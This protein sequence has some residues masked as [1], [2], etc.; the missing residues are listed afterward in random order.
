MTLEHLQEL[1]GLQEFHH[2]TYREKALYCYQN[3]DTT[4]S[5]FS[6]AGCF[7][8]HDEDFPEACML[9][10]LAKVPPKFE[11]DRLFVDAG[12]VDVDEDF[13]P[14]VEDDKDSVE[15]IRPPSKDIGDIEDFEF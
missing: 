15:V 4:R 5:G 6:L 13:F 7:Y 11:E 10:R 3:D 8:L 14:E 1:I 2:G 9:V 12:L